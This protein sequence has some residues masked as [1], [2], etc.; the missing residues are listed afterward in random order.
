MEDLDKEKLKLLSVV[1]F[2]ANKKT[3]ESLEEFFKKKGIECFFFYENFL[4]YPINY[5][6]TN[7]ELEKITSSFPFLRRYIELPEIKFIPDITDLPSSQTGILL[8]NA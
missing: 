8:E 7:K 2:S 5:N 4:S 6:T 3:V 1:A